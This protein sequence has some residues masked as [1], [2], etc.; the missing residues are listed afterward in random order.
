VDLSVVRVLGRRRQGER[1]GKAVQSMTRTEFAP[2]V[3]VCVC[4]CIEKESVVR[5]NSDS[6]DTREIFSHRPGSS[7][8]ERSASVPANLH[9]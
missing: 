6:L 8:A 1:R 2:C 5:Q 7:V 3:S 9:L 4:G